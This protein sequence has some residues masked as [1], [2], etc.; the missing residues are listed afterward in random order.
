MKIRLTA[1]AYAL[2]V[3][4]VLAY[5]LLDLPIQVSDSFGNMLKL[6][7]V[8]LGDLVYNEFWQRAFLRPFLWAELKIV[9]DLA[10]G[11]YSV[12]Y[13]NVHV[14]Q[15]AVLA[16][17]YVKL[18]RPR[19]AADLAVL[20]VGLAA[21]IGI[22]TFSGTVAEA[23]PINT[24]LTI[25]LLVFGAAAVVMSR[26]RWW[27]DVL[28]ALMAVVAALT[29]ES[30]LLVAVIVIG[31]AL[32]RAPGVSRTG[33][34]VQVALLVGYFALRF[35]ILDVGSPGLSE[36]ASGFGFGRIERDV[37]EQRFGANPL[38]FYAYNVV[39]SILSVLFAEPRAGVWR[40]TFGLTVGDPEPAMVVN[41]IASTLGTAAIAWFAW[42]RRH[43]WLARDFSDDDRLVLL[44]ALVLV[45]NGA[46]SFPYTK[47]VVMS[48]AG[49]FFAVAMAVALRHMAAVPRRGA[50]LAAAAAFMLVLSVTWSVRVIGLHAMLREMAPTVRNEWVGAIFTMPEQYKA[51]F[52]AN[53][54]G[55]RLMR[56]LHDDAVHRRPA[57]RPRLRRS[58]WTRW[59]DLD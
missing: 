3:A 45:A 34:M 20:P 14:L 16:L 26:Y 2:G 56:Q 44:F 23:F 5:F 28:L 47:D 12:W 58:A 7:S 11:N 49:A 54:L 31:A 53:P 9:F 57:V 37:L 51:E 22:H 21:L 43:A 30:G 27:N 32:V 59:L 6:Q 48:P 15:V 46:I 52:A 39:T 33:A 4:A 40:L 10:D 17:L 35:V 55:P 8:S 24:F 50:I 38:P 18:L 36:R 1:Y 29:V 42:Q 19:T 25:L 13:R 41:V